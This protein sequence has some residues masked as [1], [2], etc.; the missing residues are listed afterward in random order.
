MNLLGIDTAIDKD[1]LTKLLNNYS[2]ELFTAFNDKVN[3]VL[4]RGATKKLDI[5]FNG[6]KSEIKGQ[7]K[8]FETLLQI[9]AT[10]IPAMLVGS[11]GTGKTTAAS[12]V[13]KVL[14]VPFYPQSVGA[15]TTKS[16][17]LGYPNANGD[18]VTTIFRKAYENGGLFLMD[19]IDAGNSNT[20]TIL[21]AALANGECS[22]PDGVIKRHKDF[23]CIAAANTFGNGANRQYVGRNQLDAATLDRFVFL[24]W[25][26]DENIESQI[27]PNPEWLKI[28]RSYR[29]AA[30]NLNMRII[31]SPRASIYGSNLISAGIKIDKVIQMTIYKGLPQ[32]DID[33]LNKEIRK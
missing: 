13:A 17:L 22:F 19:E 31:I 21:N 7:H 32:S 30:E 9:V 26:I 11:A 14:K 20:I 15:Q 18:Y 29:K 6:Q 27:C 23:Y 16:D 25:D 33:K 10:G 8:E 4:E 2:N 5:N 24:N 28:V 3:E 12:K 1:E